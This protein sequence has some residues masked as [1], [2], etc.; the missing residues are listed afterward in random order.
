MLH[1]SSLFIIEI[2]QISMLFGTYKKEGKD[3]NVQR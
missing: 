2:A 3:G 1:S